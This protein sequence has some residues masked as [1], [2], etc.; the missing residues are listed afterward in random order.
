MAITKDLVIGIIGLIF[1]LLDTFAGHTI[2]ST[3][4]IAQ[5]AQIIFLIVTF[6]GAFMHKNPVQTSNA[7]DTLPTLPKENGLE[8]TTQPVNIPLPDNQVQG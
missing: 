3:D 4:Q 5:I 2:F 7:V 1:S 8:T 6:A